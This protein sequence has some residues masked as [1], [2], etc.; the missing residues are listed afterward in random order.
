MTIGAVPPAGIVVND[1]GQA[2]LTLVCPSTAGGRD[3]CGVLTIHLPNTLV[4]QTTSLSTASGT[5][6]ARFS[7]EKI[8]SGQSALIVVR[9]RPAVLRRLQTLR[10]RRVKVTLSISNHLTGG[11]AVNSTD[12]LFLLI[13]PLP[14][15]ACPVPTGQL[16]AAALGPVTLGA[17]RAHT[18]HILPRFSVRSYHTDNYCLFRGSGIRVG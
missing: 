3:A 14:T 6:L 17:T 5:V 2:M 10:I 16:S 9:L 8:A 18:R 1:Q 13:P 15:D 11:P 12:T 4:A 7:S